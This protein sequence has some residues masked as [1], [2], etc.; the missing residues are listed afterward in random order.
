[1]PLIIG[2]FALALCLRFHRSHQAGAL[3]KKITKLPLRFYH[4]AWRACAIK[5]DKR[6]SILT[7]KAVIKGITTKFPL[8]DIS[9]STK[10]NINVSIYPAIY[11]TNIIN[12]RFL[13]S[14]SIMVLGV[15][16]IIGY[17]IGIHYTLYMIIML[18][19][20]IEC[21]FSTETLTTST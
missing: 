17:I 4:V 15:I 1:M 21:D 16:R 13:S 8:Y 6:S 9:I 3:G 19:T 5:S 20:R 11:Y 12:P 14:M 10:P 18:T 2:P 7:I